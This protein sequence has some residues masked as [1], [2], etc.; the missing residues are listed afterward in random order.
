MRRVTYSILR[1]KPNSLSR[2]TG[3]GQPSGVSDGEGEVP[4][5]THENCSTKARTIPL[6]S[7]LCCH[8]PSTHPVPSSLYTHR[9]GQW[10]QTP[11]GVGCS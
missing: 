5:H 10:E 11:S 1:G 8:D 9:T 6:L 3:A 7:W 4:T 2:G